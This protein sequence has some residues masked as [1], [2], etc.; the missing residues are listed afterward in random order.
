L[1]CV[2]PLEKFEEAFKRLES[3]HSRGKV[4]LDLLA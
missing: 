3:G 1:D 2:F 4:V